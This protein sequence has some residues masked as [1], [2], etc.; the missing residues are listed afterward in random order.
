MYRF[1]LFCC[2]FWLQIS[3][4]AFANESSFYIQKAQQLKLH[5]HKQWKR[6][7]YIAGSSSLVLSQKFFVSGTKDLDLEMQAFIHTLLNTSDKEPIFCRFP[8]RAKW[9][10]KTLDIKNVA[11][12]NCPS[13]ERYKSMVYPQTVWI[14]FASHYLST[15]ASSY[16][17]T[18]LRLSKSSDA[19]S[20]QSEL[21]DYS[22]TLGANADTNNALIYAVKGLFGGFTSNFAALPYYYKIREYNDF[23]SRDLWSYQLNLNSTEIDNLV[24]LLWELDEILFPYYYLTKN[25][26]YYLLALLDAT[27][28]NFNFVDAV[29][30]YVIPIQTIKALHTHKGF[31]K[32]VRFR[33]S[34]RRQFW[35]AYEQLNAEEKQIYVKSIDIHSDD[36]PSL[37]HDETTRIHL[38]DVALSQF[39]YAYPK[40][41]ME[42]KGPIY[43]R[44]RK[45]L[46]LRSQIPIASIS[47]KTEMSPGSDPQLGHAPGR[48]NFALGKISIPQPGSAEYFGEIGARFSYHELDDPT[49]GHFLS[50]LNMFD[51]RLRYY[52]SGAPRLRAHKATFFDLLNLSP[53]NRF[54][55]K[56]SWSAEISFND[57][58]EPECIH[59][60]GIRMSGG[61]G[62]SWRMQNES[63]PLIFGLGTA[64]MDAYQTHAKQLQAIPAAGLRVGIWSQVF[65]YNDSAQLDFATH[66]NP[67]AQRFGNEGWVRELHARYSFGI[68]SE[69]LLHLSYQQK[70]DLRFYELRLSQYM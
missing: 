4:P 64:K 35:T 45:Y 47:S 23:E 11:A 37:T 5:N 42:A 24:D 14:T 17:H 21:L 1:F 48:Y 33:P 65:L 70:N 59:C 67:F 15:P 49:D 29:P 44:K 6:F 27:N 22:I 50:Q 55:R 13:Y 54:E 30:F 68:G 25:C 10:I 19:E 9:L 58:V 56:A 51:F 7:Y 62:A 18:L 61:Y 46:S 31:V 43:A 16:G 38:L 60:Y 66:Y 32:S 28:E 52:N 2:Y 12:A 41:M 20:I 39:D 57:F 63:G 26:S 40:D 53:I 8:A 36:T 3:S 69:R 34:V